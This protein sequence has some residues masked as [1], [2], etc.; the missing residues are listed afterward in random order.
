LFAEWCVEQPKRGRP[1]RE[2][3]GFHRSVYHFVGEMD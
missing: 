2:A 1:L 3:A